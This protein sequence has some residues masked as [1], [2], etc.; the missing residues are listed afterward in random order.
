[1][2]DFN[3]TIE[4]TIPIRPFGANAEE[5]IEMLPKRVARPEQPTLVDPCLDPF[6]WALRRTFSRP[7]I[8]PFA[9]AL[10]RLLNPPVIALDCPSPPKPQGI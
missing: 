7:R 6:L 4:N 9:R 8:P 3:E 2:K 10:L 1:L 5:F